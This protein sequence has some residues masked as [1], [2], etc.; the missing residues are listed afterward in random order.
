MTA[1]AQR[2][3]TAA[4]TQSDAPEW[5]KHPFRIFQ[6]NIREVDSGLDVQRNVRDIVEFGCNVWLLNAGGIVSH[7]PSKLDHQ[8]PS[9]WLKDRPSGDLLKDAIEEAHTHGVRVMARCDFS[10]LHR[11]QFEKHP[12]WFYLSPTGQRQIY[13]GLY[14]ACP[15]GPYY[16]EK[17]L[18]VIAEILDS[19]AV[20]AFFFNMFGM[21]L[22]DYSGNYHGICQCVNC[23]RRFG[24]F[25]GGMELPKEESY[26][27][28]AYPVWR[29]YTRELLDGL[30]GRVRELIKS[31]R[32]DV[33]LLL[34]SNPDVTFHEINNAVDRALPLW[35]YHAGEAAKT[36]RSTWPGRP[37][38]INCVMFWDI[39]YRFAAEQP[40]MV[41]LSLA[42]VI[43]NGANPYS[44]VLGHTANQPDRKNFGAVRRMHQFHKAN[45]RWYDGARS[46]SHVLLVSPT[47]SQDVYGDEF[48]AKAQAA[49][50][51]AYRALVESHIPFD[52][53]PD[54]KLAEA[55]ADGRLARYKA[56]VLPNAAALSDAQCAIL[57]GFVESGGGLVATFETATRDEQGGTRA[58][59]GIGLASLGAARVLAK[60]DGVK[61]LRG[62]YLRVTDRADLADL[63]DTD[64]VPVDRAFLY[65]EPRDGA[66]PSFAFVGPGRYGPPEKCW[67]D[68]EMETGHPGLLWRTHGKGRTAYFPWPVDTLFYGHSLMECRSLLSH[69]VRTV[70][71]GAQVETDLPPQVEVTV[72]TQPSSG[73]TLVHFVNGSGHQDRSYF[74]PAPFLERTVT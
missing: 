26:A 65:V 18:E 6:T 19:Y 10:K 41:Q 27:D 58:G 63:P 17:S 16:Q 8:H 28:P 5:W 55:E 48:G 11:D 40:G 64:L 70:A 47:Q 67:W 46:A 33:C 53:L 3:G 7:Y 66:E 13:N 30:A 57:D 69:A 51:G 9:P 68:D 24:A 61:E 50:R 42:Q 4:Q 38:A 36:S 14:S 34:N 60:R 2:T 49:F 31:R 39:P 20:D 74:E 72:H 54:T 62:A 56:V 12:D 52:V 73:A 45:E 23:R 15:S 35:R 71:G 22:R 21:A 37:V 29:R 25:S 44:Y 43:A 59:G 1:T 32:P